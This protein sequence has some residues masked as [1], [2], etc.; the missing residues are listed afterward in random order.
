MNID[1]YRIELSSYGVII[2]ELVDEINRREHLVKIASSMKALGASPLTRHSYVLPADGRCSISVIEEMLRDILDEE[3]QVVLV[4]KSD[5]D[6]IATAFARP[7]TT[8]GVVLV[9]RRPGEQKR[10]RSAL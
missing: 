3:D 9:G 4:T 6:M 1:R 7:R 2:I 8:G 10:D 5:Q